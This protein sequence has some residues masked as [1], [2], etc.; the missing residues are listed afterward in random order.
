MYGLWLT[1]LAGRETCLVI[2]RHRT[3]RLAWAIWLAASCQKC[4]CI[5]CD[6]LLLL[7]VFLRVNFLEVGSTRDLLPVP[8]E[9]EGTLVVVDE[10][11][12]NWIRIKSG[13]RN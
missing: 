4:G 5:S 6:A 10:E 11:T 9:A 8:E 12:S 2:V 1:R 7:I 13:W 3:N